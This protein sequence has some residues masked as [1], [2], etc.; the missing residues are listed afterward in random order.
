MVKGV[1]L[2]VV[3]MGTVLFPFF[4]NK[5]IQYGCL[6]LNTTFYSYI[7]ISYMYIYIIYIIYII[8]II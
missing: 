1:H 2:V 4:F 6:F 5:S 3:N 8:H 7:Y